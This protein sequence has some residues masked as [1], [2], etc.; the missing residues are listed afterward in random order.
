MLVATRTAH[1]ELGWK[2]TF[3][4]SFH[5]DPIDGQAFIPSI[6]ELQTID[7]ITEIITMSLKENMT[8]VSIE[9]VDA[10]NESFIYGDRNRVF[11]VL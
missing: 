3:G 10:N 2:I 7:L 11:I 8:I 6:I 4:P 1:C 5:I 9:N